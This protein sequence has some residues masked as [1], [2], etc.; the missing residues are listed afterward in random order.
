V[1]WVFVLKAVL[2]F[3]IGGAAMFGVQKLWLSNIKQQLAI[4]RGCDPAEADEADPG[5]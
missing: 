5:R 1:S 3:C 2:A 4:P